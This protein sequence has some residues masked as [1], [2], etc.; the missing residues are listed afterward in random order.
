MQVGAARNR[1]HASGGLQGS[2]AGRVGGL[3][4]IWAALGPHQW[5]AFSLGVIALVHSLTP[6]QHF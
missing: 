5:A 1:A 2:P 6:V 4:A 3:G